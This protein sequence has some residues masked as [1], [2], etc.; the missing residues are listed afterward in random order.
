MRRSEEEEERRMRKK[1]EAVRTC[2]ML[3]MPSNRLPPG[4][5]SFHV[6]QITCGT[7]CGRHRTVELGAA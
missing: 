5:V 7:S 6:C 3:S 2:T 1:K 4:A